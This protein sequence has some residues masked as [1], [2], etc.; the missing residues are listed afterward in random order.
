MVQKGNPV[1]RYVKKYILLFIGSII[2]AA[3]L[4][5]FLI[6]NQIIDGGVVGISILVSHLTG[7]SIS[8]SLVAVESPLPLP[9]LHSFG[10][11]F[12]LSTLFS[13]VSLAFWVSFF[14][15]SPS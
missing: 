15:R 14:T 8:I 2:A 7:I 9:R 1:V 13:V 10:K 3:G 5:F 12:C 11:T 6:P 4:E